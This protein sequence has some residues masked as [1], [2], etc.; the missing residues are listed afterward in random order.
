[1]LHI[2]DS[3]H[4]DDTIAGLEF[5]TYKPYAS[6]S[7]GPSD[8]IRIPVSQQDIVTAPFESFLHLTGS[9]SAEKPGSDKP[10]VKLI[11]NAMAYLFEDIRYEIC[12]IEID[13]SKNLGI[14]TTIKNILSTRPGEN[15]LGNACW[16]GVGNTKGYEDFSF[17]IPLKLLLG[18][19]EDY[20][21]VI[22]NVKQELILLRS[23][24]DNNA[25]ISPDATAVK[26]EIKSITW[27]VPHIILSDLTRLKMFKMVEKDRPIDLTF[28]SWSLFEYPEL[29]NS[30]KHSWN[31][32]TSNVLEKP[33]YVILAFQ[34][35]RKNQIKKDM[36][37]FD[38]C[39]VTNVKLYLNSQYYPYDQQ[40]GDMSIFYEA[41]S[42]FQNSY[43][44][45][46]NLPVVDLAT[47]KEKT[48]LYVIDCSH[49]NDSIKSGSVDIRLEFE[50]KQNI[51]KKTT[52]YCLLI[53]DSHH[54]YSL[55]TGSV[56][57]MM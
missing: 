31:I 21:K 48:P 54:T 56:K 43:Y 40:R 25:I 42:R 5:H 36:S 17:T 10:D 4:Y 37:C 34:K 13:R 52:A 23:Q 49:Q 39:E 57:K 50:T 18:F 51:P 2:Q 9:L 27:R 1:M 47:F 11:N 26:I 12:G 3:A 32:K 6:T 38:D 14:T 16:L 19:A 28:R 44:G 20:K 7:F 41:F 8:E 33:R 29:S 22:V 55:L 45:T 24:N 30:D 35:D 46:Q 53:H 15:H